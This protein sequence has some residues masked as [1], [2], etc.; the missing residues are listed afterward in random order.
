MVFSIILD[1]RTENYL[2]FLMCGKFAF[3]WFSKTV[4]L[5]SNSII[6]NKGLIAKIN[7]SKTLFPMALVQESLYRQAAVFSLLFA[8]LLVFGY[9]VNTVWFWL[10]PLILVNYL[11]IVA[12][13][14]IAASM[15][16]VVR[17]FTKLVPLAMTFLLF[18]LGIFWDVHGLDDPQ[19]TEIVLVLNPLAFI[20]DAYRQVLMYQT[21]PDAFTFL[22]LHCYSQQ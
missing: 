8:V 21:S 4:T 15:V 9:P 11:M 10:L 5:A 22:F 19:K 12:C 16:C 13:A 2:V 7:V 20:L 17:D 3:I 14:L 1:T 6:V 18:T